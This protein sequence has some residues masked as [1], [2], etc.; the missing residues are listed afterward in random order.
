MKPS[1]LIIADFPNWAYYEIQ[2]FLKINLS[3]DFAIYTDFVSFNSKIKSKN[4][5]KRIKTYLEKNK[6]QEIRK[7]QEYDVVLYLS[8]Y[9]EDLMKIKWNAKRIIKGIYTDSFPPKNSNFVGSKDDFKDKFLKNADAIVCG[10]EQIKELYQTA[11]DKVYYA[12]LVLDEIS[13][14]RDSKKEVNT[15]EKFIVG[16]TGNPNREFKGYY[17]HIIPAV[18][19][20]QKKHPKI[21]LKSRFSGPMETLP[22]FYNDVDV[23]LIASDADAG[24]SLFG[25]ASLME[26]PCISTDI[27]WPHQTISNFNNGFIIEKEIEEFSNKIIELYEN[28]ALLFKMSKNIRKDFLDQYSREK[29]ANNWKQLFYNVL[30]K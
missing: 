24:P 15:S 5:I 13:F 22:R 23:V 6:Y 11:H 7:D 27:G 18:A 30:N 25:E 4:P 28:R 26:V 17:S 19:L 21:E 9:F 12:N 29:M 2:Q 16:W 20:A 1:I 8:F 3:D 10:S 14:K